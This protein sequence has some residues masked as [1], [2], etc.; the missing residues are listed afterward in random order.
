MYIALV[1]AAACGGQVATH[2]DAVD[3]HPD[4][5]TA[6]YGFIGGYN[7]SL[8]DPRTDGIARTLRIQLQGIGDGTYRVEAGG[9]HVELVEGGA[10]KFDA[11]SGSITLAAATTRAPGSWGSVSGHI[12]LVLVDGADSSHA[13]HVVAD[14]DANVTYIG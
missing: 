9:A 3:F 8:V 6:G 10:Q 1:S 11:V 14:Y 12:D 4:V 2:V 7:V 13:I 5:G